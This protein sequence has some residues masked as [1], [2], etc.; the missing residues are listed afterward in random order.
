MTKFSSSQSID[1]LRR[2]WFILI[3]IVF[4]LYTCAPT[5]G[6]GDTALLVDGIQNFKIN[7]HVNNHN[8]TVLTGKL[9]SYLPI[10]DIAYRANL[11]SVFWGSLSIILFYFLLLRIFSS[12]L[13]AAVTS[14]LF[15][16]SNS[17][18]WHSTLSEV[19][20]VNA[21]FM[22]WYLHVL[23]SLQKKFEEK[24]L[25]A[26]FFIS[27]LSVFNHVEMGALSFGSAAYL[28]LCMIQEP[29]KAWR[30]F[31]YSSL[32][33]FVGFLPYLLTFLKDVYVAK[34]FANTFSWALGGD[35]KGIMFKGTLG[36]ALRETGYL[37][38]NQFPSFFLLCIPPGIYLAVKSWGFSKSFIAV[39]VSTLVTTYFFMFY[40]T[41]DKFAFMLPLFTVLAFF[42]AFAVDGVVR[43]LRRQKR[44]LLTGLAMG[45]FGFS[46][47]LPPYLYANQ[48]IWGRNPQSYWFRRYNNFYTEN[49]HDVSG[50]I[51]DPNKRNYYSV[52]QFAKLVFEKLPQG[53]VL[54]DDDSR[55]YYPLAEY[56][57]RY[58]QARPDLDIRLVNSW[59]FQNWGD[60]EST[61]ARMLEEAYR[62]GKDFF[63]VT[64]KQPFYGLLQKVQNPEKYQFKEF[65]LDEHRWIYRL[66]TAK[67][68]GSLDYAGNIW[69]PLTLEEPVF[70]N[71]T[72]ETLLY[73]KGGALHQQ[74]MSAFAGE[75]KNN[76]QVFLNCPE[77]GCEIAFLIRTKS[78]T[79]V[80]MEIYLTHGSDF[81]LVEIYL[82]NERLL[83]PVDL[84]APSVY[85]DPITVENVSL[86][87]GNN[88]LIVRSIGKNGQSKGFH[89]GID[90][91][92]L[93]TEPV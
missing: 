12:R 90:G 26:L 66:V 62:T 25:Y 91:I 41:W 70:L 78:E 54:F 58:Y 69:E 34:S 52:Q 82:N 61:F 47:I 24:N 38:F 43:Y 88:L 1:F 53:A 11:V 73:S 29:K 7:S 20:A 59:G 27:G 15:M 50:Y 9:F 79:P 3:P 10:G 23:Y 45:A 68:K 46:M 57:Q 40:N 22:V 75:W 33:F 19:Y 63:L 16:V 18:W 32:S 36:Y 4:Y 49:T 28:L 48:A 17:M 51:A 60:S 83:D 31:L 93:Q 89:I 77:R 44:P 35:F 74:E 42:G 86:E 21:F 5:I 8:I 6:L 67:D 84:Y 72:A 92:H 85:R 30:Y 65:F 87:Q 39:T 76:D 13:T 55:T 56:Y 2:H 64:N 14:A 80:A 71:W 81:G 37:I